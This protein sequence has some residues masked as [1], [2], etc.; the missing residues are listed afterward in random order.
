MDLL[1]LLLL[2]H[3][4]ALEEECKTDPAAREGGELGP[5]GAVAAVL[6]DLEDTRTDRGGKVLL[7][8][9]N[10][11]LKLPL[12]ILYDRPQIQEVNYNI[13]ITQAFWSQDMKANIP[14][15]D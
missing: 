13:S 10:R 2:V 5:F 4:G 11:Y 3:H 9:E 7:P 6:D 15:P 1:F 8:L 12:E 14:M